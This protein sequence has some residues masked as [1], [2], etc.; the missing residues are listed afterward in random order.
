MRRSV[1]AAL[2]AAFA[3]L[4]LPLALPLLTWRVLPFGD[5]SAF[6]VPLRFIYQEALRAGDSFLWSSWLG[7]GLYLH[8]EGQIGM[9][10]PAH[11]LLY[12]FLPL[13]A[14]VNLDML[15]AFAGA[16]AGLW[17]LLR[18]LGIRGDAAFGG[19]LVFAFGGYLLPHLNQL[20]PIVVAAHIPWVVLAADLL[21]RGSGR[22][23]AVGFAGAALTL[24]SEILLGYPQT[25]WMTV[26]VLGWFVVYRLAGGTPVSRV[27]LLGIALLL[28]LAIGGAQ[29][30]PTLDAARESFR[31]AT[32]TAFRMSFSL[33]PL[34][35]VQL[36]SPYALKDGIYAAAADEWFPHEL[37]LYDGALAT[38]SVAWVL[39]R[40]R[41]LPGRGL[42]TAFLAL[43]AS[44]RSSRASARRR[45]T[46]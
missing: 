10:H 46:S 26:V 33:H 4:F 29:L 34:N 2:A 1:T 3:I 43:A 22:T 5:F 16:A 31:S 30:L 24:G 44:F 18:R 14:A 41:S 15:G 25:V 32:T 36:F 23:A 21:L 38:L 42:A 39:A 27:V 8:A 40:R 6:Q 9:A 19:A 45:G 28:G 13:T 12:R 17:L 20:T 11:L 37:T 7:S 35:V